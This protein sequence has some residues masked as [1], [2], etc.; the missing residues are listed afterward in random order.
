MYKFIFQKVK[1]IIP[2][3]SKTELIALR[4]GG[5]SLDREIFQGKIDFKN[6]LSSSSQ[7]LNDLEKKMMQKTDVLLKNIGEN[8]IY[9]NENIYNVLDQLGKD[10][11]LSMI[12]DQK[13]N[14]NRI[15]YKAQSKILSK[16]SS[17]NPSLGV[18]TMVP[19]SLGPAELLL[20]Y[21]TEMQKN[22]Y[23][24]KLA[25][26][27]LIPCFGLT[28]PE[29][30]SDAT[31]KIDRGI[32]KKK[33]GKILI[34]INLNKRYITLAPVS[35]LIG[36]A[37]N[38]EDPDKLLPLNIEPGITVALIE[39]G[40]RGLLQETYHNPNNA[41]FPNGTLK[42]EIEIDADNI[43]GGIS[44]IGNGWKMLMDCLT[45][46]RGIS[47]PATANGSSKF[48]TSC[49][50]HYLQIRHQ[51]NMPIGK[52]EAVR[53][54]FINM[55]INTW[56]IH[57][58]VAFTNH[59]LDK[60]NIPSVIT[61]IMKYQTTERAR[62]IL[63]EGMDIYAGSAICMGENNFFTKFYQASPIGITVEGSNTLTRNLIIFGQGL[64]K[65]HPHIFKIF[66]SIQDDDLL[67]FKIYFNEM[68][69]TILVNYGKLLVGNPER[70]EKLTLKFSLLANFMALLGGQIKSKQMLSGEMADILSNL[71]LSYALIWYHKKEF[72]KIDT[73]LLDVCL[74]YLL[75]NTEHKINIVIANYPIKS[76]KLFLYPLK[77]QNHVENYDEINKFYRYIEMNN[78][79]TDVFEE[80]I[81]SKNTILEKMQKLKHIKNKDEYTKLYKE[82][83]SV[84]EFK[85]KKL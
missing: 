20:H 61:A 1:T 82:I 48:I 17:Y 80:D 45:I 78:G 16:I 67:I 71:Y 66:E 70:L 32:V 43:I 73:I 15:S 31:G 72:K 29:N 59:L 25:D 33:N 11:F 64:N 10:G 23:L 58:S 24:P 55:F 42:G 65:S 12:I 74:H 4:S 37:F 83:I 56:I 28:G 18:I 76:L 2:K 54:K 68:I 21:G 62:I 14:G 53:K 46:G 26:G 47:L 41:G 75:D 6:L 60:G 7:P 39:K 19:N 13:Y 84:G 27:S 9:P 51:F 50:Y 52:M 44:N 8:P 22:K 69:H 57:S 38:V 77:C 79:F 63:N 85:I 49:M 35:N 30:G 36:I 5:V 34:H 3:I 81:Y 40:H